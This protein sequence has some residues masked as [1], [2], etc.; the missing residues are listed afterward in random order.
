MNSNTQ[1]LLLPRKACQLINRQVMALK[2]E[3]GATTIRI[4]IAALQTEEEIEALQES[5]ETNGKK[6]RDDHLGG[7]DSK[8]E[9]IK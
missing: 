1:I 9:E 5:H 6:N 8:V 3:Y 2:N 4:L 7:H